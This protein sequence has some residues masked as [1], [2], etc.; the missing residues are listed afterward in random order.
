MRVLVVGAVSHFASVLTHAPG[1]L[2]EH[3]VQT[4][5]GDVHDTKAVK[6]MLAGQ[7]AVIYFAPG[8]DK[9][10]TDPFEALDAA[11]RGTFHLMTAAEEAGVR[12]VVLV[13]TL[14]FFGR[15]PRDWNVDTSWRPR[16]TPDPAELC[17][18]LAELSVREAIRASP[19]LRADCLRLGANVADVQMVQA[20]TSALSEPLTDNAAGRWRI[21]HVGAAAGRPTNQGRPWREVFA[22]AVPLA[23]RPIKNVVVF[24]AGGILRVHGLTQAQAN[25]MP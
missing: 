20:I 4:F 13:S 7:E 17:P 1:T 16:P 23:S 22:P 3:N 6:S 18:W 8:G 9:S 5:S 10:T 19:G 14:T 25:A 21:V 24:G 2:S 12:R 11:T 15:H